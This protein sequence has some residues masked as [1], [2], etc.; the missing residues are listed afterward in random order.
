MTFAESGMLTA[1]NQVRDPKATEMVMA[2]GGF[3]TSLATANKT[4]RE[5]NLSQPAPAPDIAKIVPE[6]KQA[7]AELRAHST[8]EAVR[9]NRITAEEAQKLPLYPPNLPIPASHPD[10]PH[11]QHLT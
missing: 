6:L 7:A 3:L 4:N 5:A 11:P 9:A 1:F 2:L 10:A 8:D